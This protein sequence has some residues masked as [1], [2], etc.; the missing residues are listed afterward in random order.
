MRRSYIML[1]K[2]IPIYGLVYRGLTWIRRH[3]QYVNE[4][5]NNR[6]QYKFVTFRFLLSILINIVAAG[7]SIPARMME[8]IALTIGKGSMNYLIKDLYG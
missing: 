6:R 3:V 5:G 4:I 2:D 1:L 7:A 8:L